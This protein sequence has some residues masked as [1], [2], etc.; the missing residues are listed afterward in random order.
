MGSVGIG[1]N[2]KE[3]KPRENASHVSE[4]AGEGDQMAIDMVVCVIVVN[5]G[6]NVLQDQV[7][8]CAFGASVGPR[9]VVNSEDQQGEGLVK[10]TGHFAV[11][12]C[13]IIKLG[14]SWRGGTVIDGG[15]NGSD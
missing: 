1:A 4:V 14:A 7:A 8:E 13:L 11:V 10:F 2:E 15:S 5:N 12:S 9:I 3:S 6:I